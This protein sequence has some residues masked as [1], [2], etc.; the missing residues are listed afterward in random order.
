MAALSEGTTCPIG[1]KLCMYANTMCEISQNISSTRLFSCTVS[2]KAWQRIENFGQSQRWCRNWHMQSFSPIEQVVPPE[3]AVISKREMSSLKFPLGQLP[4]SDESKVDGVGDIAVCPHVAVAN[5][6]QAFGVYLRAKNQL[7]MIELQAKL[8]Y[9]LLALLGE[10]T[11]GQSF[12]F[13][14]MPVFLS[15]DTNKSKCHKS[16]ALHSHHEV[17]GSNPG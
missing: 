8:G 3:R 14:H 5:G 17:W 16:R 2:K 12:I 4:S 10:K 7:R 1:P 6:L 15:H 13:E 9:V 11:L